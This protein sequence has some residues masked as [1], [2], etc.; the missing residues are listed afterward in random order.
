MLNLSDLQKRWITAL[1]IAVP[2]VLVLLARTLWAVAVAAVLASFIAGMEFCYIF[3]DR[4]VQISRQVVFAVINTLFPLCAFVW[5]VVGLH[6][7][8]VLV[9]FS[10]MFYCLILWPVNKER[11]EKMTLY[12]FGWVY[13]GYLLG[14]LPLFKAG[15]GRLYS[16]PVWFVLFTVVAT[17]V[18]AFFF[19]RRFGKRPLYPVVSPKKTVEGAIGGTVCAVIVGTLAGTLLVSEFNVFRSFMVAVIVTVL[20]QAGD[21]IESMFKR[22]QGVKD[23][24]SI[25]PG[26]G[27]LLDRLDSLLFSFPAVWFAWRYFA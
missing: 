3:V 7:C 13:T 8:L 5:G 1:I 26:H 11:L 10:C 4:N 22:Q 17:D 15:D 27:G 21:L 9:L 25:L 19:G 16:G 23:S 2:L 6:F 14:Y 12:F 18:G 20:A 24:G